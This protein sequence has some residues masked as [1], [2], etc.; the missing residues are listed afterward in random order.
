MDERTS[1][2]RN[3]RTII[4]KGYAATLQAGET[5]EFV[6]GDNLIKM[7]CIKRGLFAVTYCSRDLTLKH[8]KTEMHIWNCEKNEWTLVEGN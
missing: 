6:S 2:R 4:L 1:R 7:A 3:I 8:L 5:K